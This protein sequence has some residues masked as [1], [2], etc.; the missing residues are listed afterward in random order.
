MKMRFFKLRSF[1][2]GFIILAS[3]LGLSGCVT[4]TPSKRDNIC[5]VLSQKSGFFNRWPQVTAAVSREFNIPAPILL[6]T[7]YVES[8]FRSEARPPRNSL[9]GLIPWK[10]PSSAYGYA[11]ALDL[12]WQGYIKKTGRRY[13]NRRSFHDS[14]H[15]IGWYHDTSARRH[16]VNRND[17]QA[18][19]IMYHLGNG[20]P[21]HLRAQLPSGVKQA[22]IRFE[23]A[24][25]LYKKQLKIC[26]ITL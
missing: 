21:T 22:A 25:E 20:Q 13:A 18:L 10:R 23:E 15:F 16:N 24:V 6:A 3:S 1:G 4:V 14:I 7:I 26:G 2:L 12:T 19:Y 5:E 11:Q 8:T 9:L 17:A